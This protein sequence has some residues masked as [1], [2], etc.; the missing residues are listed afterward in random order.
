VGAEAIGRI[1]A[2]AAE[3]AVVLSR[4]GGGATAAHGSAVQAI[5]LHDML[6]AWVHHFAPAPAVDMDVDPGP[7]GAGQAGG[8]GGWDEDAGPLVRFLAGCVVGYDT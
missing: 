2:R 8:W 7:T 6:E 1:E 4:L 3:A 5:V